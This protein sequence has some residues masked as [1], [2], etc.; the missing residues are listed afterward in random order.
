[1]FYL[2]FNNFLWGRGEFFLVIFGRVF[3]LS[4]KI[5]CLLVCFAVYFCPRLFLKVIMKGQGMVG[6]LE[7]YLGMW[8]PQPLL[9]FSSCQTS[10]LQSPYSLDTH[11][12]H[13]LLHTG[14]ADWKGFGE[15]PVASIFQI[16]FLRVS[17]MKPPESCGTH[18]KNADCPT[19]MLNLE[20]QWE[21]SRETDPGIGSVGRSYHNI[22]ST[23]S[24][25]FFCRL[26]FE[27]HCSDDSPDPISFSL[28]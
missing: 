24:P 18:I 19:Q 11:A 21:W 28:S 4:L 25:G 17:F 9:G 26:E 23:N 15:G 16:W 20:Y 1:M 7:L 3:I 2:L 14:P 10:R 5:L 13:T 12:S 6:T 8:G 22:V 27:N